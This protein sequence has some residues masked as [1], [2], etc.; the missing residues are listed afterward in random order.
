[1]SCPSSRSPTAMAK[2]VSEL[3]PVP[4]PIC[5]QLRTQR[6]V[7]ILAT[8]YG[9]TI[10]AMVLHLKYGTMVLKKNHYGKMSFV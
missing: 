6:E 8:Y 9:L 5:D 7:S 10:V 1:M 4:V 3:A 2:A